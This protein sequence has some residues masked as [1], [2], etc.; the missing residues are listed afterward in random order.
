MQEILDAKDLKKLEKHKEKL[1]NYE[2]MY[3]KDAI[4][5]AMKKN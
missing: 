3:V 5:N 4:Q 1:S 2:Y